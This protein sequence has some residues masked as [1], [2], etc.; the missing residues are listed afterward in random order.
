MTAFFFQDFYHMP[1][2][3]FALRIT[4]TFLVLLAVRLF[5]HARYLA[6]GGE[7]TVRGLVLLTPLVWLLVIWDEFDA[8]FAASLVIFA[9]AMLALREGAGIDGLRALLR[10]HQLLMRF[11]LL[12]F[13]VPLASYTVFRI[14]KGDAYD[15]VE[16]G[17]NVADALKTLV[18]HVAEGTGL[19]RLA[20]FVGSSPAP[21]SLLGGLGAAAC[22]AAI[23]LSR[24]PRAPGHVAVAA[25]LGCAAMAALVTL[26][27]AA[28]ARYQ[29]WCMAEGACIYTDS[30]VSYLWVAAA[31]YFL[32]HALADRLA[33]VPRTAVLA[34]LGALVAA[35]FLFTHARNLTVAARMDRMAGV[36]VHA[37]A[38][39]CG[40]LEAW[41]DL[42]ADALER[43]VDPKTLVSMHRTES[44]A[45]YWRLYLRHHSAPGR[46]GP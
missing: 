19:D 45:G 37:R 40:P 33:S 14:L 26:P 7:G 16:V 44:R 25:A 38:I 23:A 2:S 46:C 10:R 39:A 13:A 31:A 20:A 6:P 17:G 3:S 21:W 43:L 27:V 32:A 28:T 24:A 36:F 4:P 11:E 22:L 30:R 15:G 8:A 1:P 34:A 5:V 12:W 18:K 9:Y 29:Q 42:D 35:G 41:R